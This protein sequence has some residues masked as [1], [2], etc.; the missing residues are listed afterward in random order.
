[1]SEGTPQDFP[2]IV[3]AT[4]LAIFHERAFGKA[5]PL[6]ACEAEGLSETD[7]LGFYA[8][9]V[10]RT[11]T[12]EQIAIFRHSEVYAV[13]RARQVACENA[14]S[15]GPDKAESGR[16]LSSNTVS[17]PRI[18]QEKMGD[19][20]RV[21]RQKLE[22]SPEQRRARGWDDDAVNQGPLVEELNY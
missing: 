11:L 12:D 16:Q 17:R 6:A 13:V 15:E 2:P 21:K 18:D 22:E 19:V 10:K 7:E 4:D 1:M 20:V 14:E 3:T 9:G 8:D 5:A